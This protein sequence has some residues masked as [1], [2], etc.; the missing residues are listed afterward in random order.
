MRQP[1]PN[2]SLSRFCLRILTA[3]DLET[4]L[5]P[6]PAGL[7][8]P[9]LPSIQPPEQP[10]RSPELESP[11]R[12]TR[13][14]RPAALFDPEARS[15]CLAR[16]AHHELMAVELFAF[17]LLRWPEMPPGLRRTLALTL[18]EEQ[19]HCRLY[20]ERLA[21]HGHQ[22][23]DYPGSNYFWRHVAAISDS[24]AGPRAF[25]AAMGLT[26][27]QANLDFTLLYRDAFRAAG[28]MESAG[29]CQ[30]VHDEEIGHVH[31]AAR[32]LDEL[33]PPGTADL[34]AYRD[35]VPF[36]LSLARAKARRF[37]A[38]SRRRAGLSEEFIEA[39]RDARSSQETG[40]V[41]SQPKAGT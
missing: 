22:L 5:R 27:E 4:K 39:V 23:G 35:A 7:P 19:T 16:F 15:Q 17:A 32:W 31:A 36:P 34:E 25:L 3:G 12:S 8:D 10:A 2:Q 13:L 11:Q 20:L 9:F 1:A 41:P 24:P 21:A 6:P 38:P 28:D 18:V 40:L 33:S 37:D 14:P 29:V 26:L 30:R